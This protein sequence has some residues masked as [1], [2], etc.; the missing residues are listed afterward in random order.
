MT[1]YEVPFSLF[2]TA[3][4][5]ADSPEEAQT[6]VLDGAMD[7]SGDID[8]DHLAVGGADVYAPEEI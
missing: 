1:T 5:E 3:T 4:V 2:G 7:W 8:W 6:L